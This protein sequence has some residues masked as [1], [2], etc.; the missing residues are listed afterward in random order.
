MAA[1]HAKLR[2]QLVGESEAVTKEEEL[3]QHTLKKYERMKMEEN[4][5]RLE[6]IELE[7]KKLNAEF[8]AEL[9]DRYKDYE[10]MVKKLAEK[11]AQLEREEVSFK[12]RIEKNKEL[13]KKK[14]AQF[15]QID[16]NDVINEH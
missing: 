10:D 1:E 7:K 2:T 9:N 14:A 11:R 12:D 5:R 3:D 6:N 13:L 16:S 15:E 4:R 8:E